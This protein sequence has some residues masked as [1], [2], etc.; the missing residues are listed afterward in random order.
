ML[1]KSVAVM[2]A[3]GDVSTTRT[4]Y[5]VVAALGLIGVGLIVLAI[6][7]IKQTRPD[8]E[9]L[10]PLERMQDRSWRTQEP[11]QRRRDLDEVRPAGA[12]PVVQHPGVP[13]VDDEFEQNLPALATFDDLQAQLA[14]DARREEPDQPDPLAASSAIVAATIGPLSDADGADQAEH[15]GA[16]SGE[17]GEAPGSTEAVAG[18][19]AADGTATH[20]TK[21]SSEIAALVGSADQGGSA[22][23]IEAA[24]ADDVDVAHTDD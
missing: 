6:W 17:T 13:A 18:N 15:A 22:P 1:T 19:A 3:A 2:A 11:A 16:K 20:S 14:A 9:L 21:G 24:P 12:R 10:A 8:P 4:V 5:L 7:L 23:Q